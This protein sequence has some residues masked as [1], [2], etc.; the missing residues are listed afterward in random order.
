MKGTIIGTDLLQKG[1]DVQIIEINTNTTIFND[2]ANL[3]DY[4]SLFNVLIS[5]NITE[6]H[7]IYTA[8]SSFFPTNAN[9]FIFEDKLKEKCLEHNIAYYPYVVP[10]NSITIPYVEDASNRFILRQAFDTTALV[11]ETYCADKFEFLNLMSGSNHIPNT[12]FVNTDLGFD[13]LITFGLAKVDTI[14]KN[15]N[16][17]NNISFKAPVCTS[18][19][20]LNRFLKFI[21]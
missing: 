21:D 16:N 3:L 4:D 7:F 18:G 11:D 17:I 19:E 5:N 15:N 13:T 2:G 8:G 6:L 10:A 12:F 14:K 1:N 9:S 20:F